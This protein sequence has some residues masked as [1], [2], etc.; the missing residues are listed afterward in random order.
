MAKKAVKKSTHGG[1]REGAG[2]PKKEPTETIR[3]P[4]AIKS[5]VLDLIAK[6]KKKQA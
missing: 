4:S 1:A 5:Q 2:Q 3:I 6:H